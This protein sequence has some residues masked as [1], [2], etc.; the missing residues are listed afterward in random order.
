MLVGC[1]TAASL[2]PFVGTIIY[3]ILRPPEY[4]EDVR[5]RELEMQAAEAR[6]HEL[7]HGAV[8]ALRLPDRARL[9]PLPEL[10][11]QAQG[12]LRELLA[13]A[14]PG[15]DDLPLLRGRGARRRAPAPRAA[16]TCHGAESDRSRRPARSR[17]RRSTRQ[18]PELAEDGR[19]WRH[20][21]ASTR[22]RECCR[23]ASTA[24]NRGRTPRA[25]ARRAPPPDLLNRTRLSKTILD[26]KRTT[27][28]AR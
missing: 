6:L 27:W 26:P 15:V 24:S 13:P 21:S 25:P 9:H 23:R 10:S 5:E 14:R 3:M 11:A 18:S 12:A 1:A 28:T 19:R 2:F 16:Q 22:G 7:D 17:E 4:L 20:A 8:P